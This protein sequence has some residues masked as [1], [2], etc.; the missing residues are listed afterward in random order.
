MLCA[1]FLPSAS[2]IRAEEERGKKRK[3]RI[4]DVSAT[5]VFL[6]SARLFFVAHAHTRLRGCF[7]PCGKEAF[8]CD[9]NLFPG[10]PGGWKHSCV[11]LRP[12]K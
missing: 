8:G 2:L 10:R 1:S 4:H 7:D 3:E 12:L 5:F 11:A 9:A 6:L